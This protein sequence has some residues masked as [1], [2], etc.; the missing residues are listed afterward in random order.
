MY[1]S[2]LSHACTATHAQQN[3]DKNIN[4]D[5][6]WLSAAMKQ[7]RG[8][9]SGQLAG[10]SYI[11]PAKRHPTKIYVGNVH[12]DAGRFSI[13]YGCVCGLDLGM[14]TCQMYV[15]Y[16]YVYMG[17]DEHKSMDT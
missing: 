11:D 15:R 10:H 14:Y 2:R 5:L 17:M 1:K 4:S 8:M 13:L 9:A 7:D 16:A 3:K 6:V 12:P